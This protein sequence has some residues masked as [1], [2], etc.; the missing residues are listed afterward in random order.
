MSDRRVH[1]EPSETDVETMQVLRLAD[2]G[3]TVRI[4]GYGEMWVNKRDEPYY[5]PQ[6]WL[7]ADDEQYRLVPAGFA[8]D[9]ELW[10]AI[11]GREG[12]DGWEL[13]DNVSAEIVE[14]G[15]TVWC[16]E[17]GELLTSLREKRMADDGVCPHE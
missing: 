16:G 5:G 6:L 8:R 13:V 15:E 3:D 11:G 1:R 12:L 17:C 14:V 7:H 2:H 10:R 9:P 4:D